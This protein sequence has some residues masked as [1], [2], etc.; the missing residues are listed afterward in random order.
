MPEPEEST[1]NV[2]SDNGVSETDVAHQDEVPPEPSKQQDQAS[3]KP[4]K[5]SRY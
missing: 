4:C 2:S 1:I 3:A 5:Q